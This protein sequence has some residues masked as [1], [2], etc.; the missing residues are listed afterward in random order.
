MTFLGLPVPEWDLL[1]FPSGAF[2]RL[3]LN[4]LLLLASLPG[5][6]LF[7][8][9]PYPLIIAFGLFSLLL[10][11]IAL[12]AFTRTLALPYPLLPF[13]LVSAGFG[14]GR[15]AARRDHSRN[16]SAASQSVS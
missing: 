15:L 3:I 13:L 6:Y 16:G 4:G 1:L 11:M 10:A 9:R 5:L 7:I 12:L 2:D 14:W 8:R